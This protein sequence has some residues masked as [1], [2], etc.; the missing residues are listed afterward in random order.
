M[1]SQDLSSNKITLYTIVSELNTPETFLPSTA[2][3][4]HKG[5]CRPSDAELDG[6]AEYVASCLT[7]FLREH[8][9][10]WFQFG[11]G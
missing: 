7:R 10:Q 9:T 6:V 8:P 2:I 11:D 3:Q 5:C 1:A 4:V